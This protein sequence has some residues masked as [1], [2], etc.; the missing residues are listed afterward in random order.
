M[1]YD[2][3]LFRAFIEMVAMLATPA[4]ALSRSGLADKVMA[5]AADHEEFAMPGPSRAD[6]LSLVG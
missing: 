2:A 3:D 6:V 1:L 4:D 5:V